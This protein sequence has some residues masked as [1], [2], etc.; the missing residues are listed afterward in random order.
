MSRATRAAIGFPQLISDNL[1]RNPLI[2]WTDC[3]IYSD[4]CSWWRH[5]METFSALLAF[6]A[7]NSPVTGEFSSQR[8]VTRSFDVTLIC[9]LNKRLSKQ[10]RYWWFETPSRSLW[11][12]CNVIRGDHGDGESG[13]S[14]P[15]QGS[16]HEVVGHVDGLLPRQ[17]PQID[18]HDG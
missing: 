5:Q 2:K 11:R 1:N 15:G 12:H 10:Q 3:L 14:G 13:N 16:S 8:P 9:A 4:C 18:V 17:T 6:C 7:G